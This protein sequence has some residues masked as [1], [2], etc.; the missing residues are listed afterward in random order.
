MDEWTDEVLGQREVAMLYAAFNGQWLLLDVLERDNKGKAK[1]FKLVA[2]SVDKDDLRDIVMD[3][4]NPDDHDYI[5][6][7][8]DP[9][10]LCDI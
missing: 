5:F 7:L 8:A 6:V 2:N 1:L 9:D 10:T 3:D 4:E